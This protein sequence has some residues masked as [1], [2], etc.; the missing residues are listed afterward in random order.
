MSRRLGSMSIANLSSLAALAAISAEELRA[1]KTTPNKHRPTKAQKKAD[2]R[3]RMAE[4][5]TKD[6]TP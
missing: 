6:Q 2:K 4:R 1:S 3:A 5:Q